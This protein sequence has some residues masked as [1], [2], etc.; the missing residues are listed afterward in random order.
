M[1]AVLG[2]SKEQ[3]KAA[4]QDMYTMVAKNPGAPLHFPVGKKACELAGYTAEQMDGLSAESLESFA[5]VGCPFRADVIKPG[6]TVLDVGSGSGT[7]VLIASKLV[8]EGG[9]VWALDLTAA[10]RK[11]LAK[12]L[13]REGIKNVEILAADAEEIPLPD[14]TVDV[15]TSNGVLNLVADKRQAIAEIF[16]VLKPKG[17]V[18]IADIVI[19]NPVTP[20]CEDDPKLWAECVVGATVDENYLNMFRDAG[21]EQIEIIRKYDYFA[22][23]PSKDTRE[24]AQQFGAYGTELRMIRGEK[25]PAKAIQWMKRLNPARILRDFQRRGLWGAVSFLLALI[26][27]Y[28]TLATVALLSMTGV[29]LALND[30]IWAGTIV[31]F[32]IITALV[33]AMGIKKHRSMTPMVLAVMGAATISYTMFFNYNILIEIAGFI[34]LAL[35]TF[36][37]FDKRRWSKVPGGKANAQDKI[38]A[39]KFL[40]KSVKN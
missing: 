5:G 16:R 12:M 2:F 33:I 10:M 13:A 30:Q 15:V 4:V 25:A 22:Y 20:D 24:I 40:S 8:G 6:D 9:K 7:D 19:S 36:L 39:K 23:S 35:S 26:A 3:I 11:K 31:L 38:R 18:Q 32:S 1:V 21:F 28:G 27:C 34:I 17:A 37:D 14:E 29:T